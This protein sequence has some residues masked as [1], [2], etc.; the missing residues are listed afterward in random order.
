MFGDTDVVVIHECLSAFMELP[1][2][3]H[4]EAPN[5]LSSVPIHSVDH[6]VVLV[7]LDDVILWMV[8]LQECVVHC[9]ARHEHILDDTG[10]LESNW[11]LENHKTFLQDA[12]GALDI[13]TKTLNLFTPSIELGR[14][15]LILEGQD[16]TSP[17]TIPPIADDV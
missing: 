3:C 10:L 7:A 1:V 17:L 4:H 5:C 2:C 15:C 13:L 9:T 11:V 6:I 14:F 12:E 16:Q 8:V